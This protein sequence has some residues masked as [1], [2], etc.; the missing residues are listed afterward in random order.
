MHE[1]VAAINHTVCHRNL[2]M[3]HEMVLHEEK[4]S[5]SEPPEQKGHDHAIQ[6]HFRDYG[7][8]A[9]RL[10]PHVHF[11][12]ALLLKEQALLVLAVLL[13]RDLALQ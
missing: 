2:Q 7:A 13:C 1:F 3:I 9:Q 10:I 11:C 6:V 8:L 12:C 4:P 5:S